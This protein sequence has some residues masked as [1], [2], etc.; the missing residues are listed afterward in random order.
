MA[1]KASRWNEDDSPL[2]SAHGGTAKAAL[3]A[4]KEARL[5]RDKERYADWEARGKPPSPSTPRK[6]RVRKKVLLG[7]SAKGVKL[8]DNDV[9]AP[10]LPSVPAV[11]KA[12]A[13]L[14]ATHVT[15]WD[16]CGGRCHYCGVQMVRRGGRNMFTLDHVIPRSRGGSNALSN[17]VGCCTECNNDKG[18]LTGEEYAAVL[19]V[20]KRRR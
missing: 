1:S 6:D 2:A 12:T 8:L 20:R 7:L 16:R 4:I 5:A 3:R 17:L 13:G 9:A 10:F 14:T 11:V 19:A 15:V 18:S